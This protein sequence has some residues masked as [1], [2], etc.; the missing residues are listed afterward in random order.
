M[1]KKIYQTLIIRPELK[2]IFWQIIF[3]QQ[4]Q[5]YGFYARGRKR[6]REDDSG[7]RLAY[8]LLSDYGSIEDLQE[9]NQITELFINR[10]HRIFIYYL[11]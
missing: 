2:K 9:D 6:F 4:G 8:G 10:S 11:V 5:L 1:L 7:F 3:V